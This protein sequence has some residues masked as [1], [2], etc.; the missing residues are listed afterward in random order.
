M[1]TSQHDIAGNY[2]VNMYWTP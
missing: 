2:E 1:S